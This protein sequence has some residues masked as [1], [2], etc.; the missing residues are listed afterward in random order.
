MPSDN[1]VNTDENHYSRPREC[2]TGLLE[3]MESNNS[4]NP[5]FLDELKRRRN[6]RRDLKALRAQRRETRMETIKELVSKQ[7]MYHGDVRKMG[8]GKK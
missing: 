8:S 4:I 3:R 6:N 1:T 5:E 2:P 7:A